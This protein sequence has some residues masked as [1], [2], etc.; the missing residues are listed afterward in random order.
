MGRFRKQQ[1]NQL[2][3]L[4]WVLQ[5]VI[6]MQSIMLRQELGLIDQIGGSSLLSRRIGY[7]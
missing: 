3:R 4:D 5:A 6:P 7:L 1:Y 2:A